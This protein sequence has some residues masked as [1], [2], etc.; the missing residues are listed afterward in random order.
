[1]KKVIGAVAVACLFLPV[2]CTRLDRV[3]SAAF[4]ISPDKLHVRV[5]ASDHRVPAE[6]MAV[7][8]HDEAQLEP[9]AAPERA[10][11]LGS[12]LI[13]EPRYEL[14]P[15]ALPTGETVSVMV[16][17]GTGGTVV[18]GE[19]SIEIPP[20]ALE[21]DTEISIT[22][23]FAA[24]E[25]GQL[26]N[27]TAGGGGYRF[28]PAGQ[29]FRTEAVIRLPYEASLEAKPAV[30]EALTTYYF[31]TE[32]ERWEALRRLGVDEEARVLIS[33][34]THFTD[35]I[36]G[37]LALP[38]G[39]EPLSFNIN[40]IKGLEAADPSAGVLQLEGLEANHMGSANFRFTLAV[41]AGRAGMT[42]AVA[43]GYSSDGGNGILG[44]GWS[45][46]AG[47]EITYDTRRGL[48]EYTAGEGNKGPFMLDGV[49][50]E[51]GGRENGGYRYRPLKESAFERILHY[52][53]P[54]DYWEVTDKRGTKR[55]YG[56]RGTDRDSDASW[57]GL[58]TGRK[59]RW[60]LESVEDSFGNRIRYEYAQDEGELYLTE[61]WYTEH[62]DS[63]DEGP[64]RVVFEYARSERQDI[65]VTGRGK[66]VAQT[67]WR[68]ERIEFLYGKTERI[69]SYRC[70]YTTQRYF[71]TT[72]LVKFGEERTSGGA[73]LWAYEFE[74]EEFEYDTRGRPVLFGDVERWDFGRHAIQE[75]HGESGGG[76]G[77]ISGGAGI[78]PS[79][80]T[81]IRVIR[82][83][84]FGGTSGYMQ[85][86]RTLVDINGD[87]K[88]DIVWM[89]GGELKAILNNGEG[90]DLGNNPETWGFEGG[91]GPG[92]IGLE[93]Q[94][95]NS[96]GHSTFVGAGLPIGGVGPNSGRTTQESWSTEEIGFADINGDGLADI[97]VRGEEFYWQNTGTS[98]IKTGYR[99]TG[100]G[101][102]IPGDMERVLDSQEKKAYDEVYY[103][104]VPF[105]AW[106][107][108]VSGTVELQQQARPARGA[109]NDSGVRL[110]TYW[111]P[112]TGKGT[113][114]ATELAVQYTLNKGDG[115]AGG[116]KTF[117]PVGR[118]NA[119]YFI[120]DAGNDI[121]NDDKGSSDIRWNIT[122][123]YT[124]MRYFEGLN[125]DPVFF[126]RKE[127]MPEKLGMLYN[128][129]SVQGNNTAIFFTEHDWKAR[130]W[131]DRD[132]YA[133]AARRGQMIPGVLSRAGFDLLQ[134]AAE[135]AT[136]YIPNEW[137]PEP[138]DYPF[139]T[140]EAYYHLSPLEALF[141]YYSY[142]DAGL[143]FCRVNRDYEAAL[144]MQDYLDNERLIALY[145]DNAFFFDAGTDFQGKAILVFNHER[146]DEFAAT[147]RKRQT[148]NYIEAQLLGL[149]GMLN[150]DQRE[151]L[152]TV[153]LPGRDEAVYP[154]Y[155]EATGRW[156][157]GDEAESPV[158]TA[159]EGSVGWYRN[160]ETVFL[161]DS[162]DGDDL[163]FDTETGAV[164]LAGTVVGTGAFIEANHGS[165]DRVCVVTDTE[166]KYRQVWHLSGYKE[167]LTR[168]S[169][170]KTAEL[171]ATIAGWDWLTEEP[172][173]HISKGWY[174]TLL[175]TIPTAREAFMLQTAYQVVGGQPNGLNT[176]ALTS[177]EQET[178]RRRIAGVVSSGFFSCYAAEEPDGGTE[179]APD[180]YR[181]VRTSGLSA[182]QEAML[183]LV[184]TALY[185]RG[186]TTVRRSIRYFED[187]VFPV[188]NNTVT[189]LTALHNGG[190]ERYTVTIAADY[191]WNSADDF[192][193][194][195][196]VA[197]APSYETNIPGY[198]AATDAEGKPKD[199]LVPTGEFETI[200]YRMETVELLPG[201][202]RQWYYGI[203]FK[204]QEASALHNA[205]PFSEAKL[206]REWIRARSIT[207]E[208]LRTESAQPPLYALIQ[209][210][211]QLEDG[212][213]SI[214]FDY[215]TGQALNGE[216]V[217]VGPVSLAKVG[218]IQTLW[219]FY[220]P[221]IAGDLIHTNR[222]GGNAYNEIRGMKQPAAAYGSLVMG[223]LN[224]S[225]SRGTDEV[226]TPSLGMLPIGISSGSNDS[227]AY[228][229]QSVQ[230]INGS[231]YAD[232]VQVAGKELLITPGVGSGTGTAFGKTYSMKNGG[233]VSRNYATVS[234][235]GLT[236]S[237]TGSYYAIRTARGLLQGNTQNGEGG[238]T[239]PSSDLGPSAG[240]G[241]NWS[242]GT[243]TQERG[244][245]DIN[246][247][248][249]PDFIDG[250]SVLLNIGSEFEGGYAWGQSYLGSGKTVSNG[251][252]ISLGA[253]RSAD[254]GSA[255]EAKAGGSVSMSGSLTVSDSHTAA[256]ETLLDINGNGLPDKVRKHANA[257][258]IEVAF[259]LGSTFADF[260]PF[261]LAS[262]QTGLL[263]LTE[264]MRTDANPPADGFSS[265]PYF[266]TVTVENKIQNLELGKFDLSEMDALDYSLSSSWGLSGG[267]DVSIQISIWIPIV[268][269]YINIPLSAGS[270]INWSSFTNQVTVRMIDINGN[271]LPDRV[272]RVA[273]STDI[274]VRLNKSGRVGLLRTISHP[275]GGR[276]AVDYAYMSGTPQMPQSKYVMSAVTREDG[277]G[278][279]DRLARG[280]APLGYHSE[281]SWTTEIVYGT[282]HY[283]RVAKEQYGFDT[284]T[285]RS[286]VDKTKRVQRFTWGVYHLKGLPVQ[287]V[288]SDETGHEW[289]R[290]TTYAYRDAP[291]ALQRQ[292][293]T[294]VW[295]N[296]QNTT[297]M[298]T[299]VDYE[300]DNSRSGPL[301]Y[302]NVTKIRDTV[303]TGTQKPP[304]LT[305][306]I[307][308]WEPG[309]AYFHAHPTGITVESGTTLIRRRTGAYDQR[310]GAL[311]LQTQKGQ[312]TT[313]QSDLTTKLTWD[314][315]GN[316]ERI[317]N[318]GS[319]WGAY[320]WDREHHQYPVTIT[321][322]GP[323]V[324]PYESHIAWDP[325][326]GVKTKETDENNQTITY[327][328]DEQG[329]LSAVYSPYDG[330]IPAVTYAYATP[331]GGRWY[332]VTRNKV[333]F[334]PGDTGGIR[335]VIAVDGLGRPLITAKDGA[336]WDGSTDLAGWNIAGPVA[337]DGKGRTVAQG[338]SVFL[339]ALSGSLEDV[340]TY[341]FPRKSGYDSVY[342]MRYPTLTEY[343]TQ[344]RPTTVTLP[345]GA[346]QRT[347]YAI[348][349]GH[350][351]VTVTDPL[352]N[353][354]VQTSDARGNITAVT[355]NSRTGNELTGA[356]YRY[357]AIG[358]MLAAV[359]YQGN[360]LSIEYD[361]M[362]RRTALTS[363]DIGRKEYV[364]DRSGNLIEESD[365]VLRGKGTAIYYEY[366]GMNRL[367]AITYPASENTVYEYGPPGSPYGSANRIV[368]VT[369][370]SGHIEYRYGALGETTAET[371]TILHMD[372]SRK[373]LYPAGV[374]Y[375]FTYRSNY[376]G[377]LEC[378]GFPDKETVRYGYNQGGQV[379][380]VTGERNG[381][382]FTYVKNIGYD[383]FSQR[384]FIEYGNGI[385]TT[386][387]YDPARRWLSGIT[388]TGPQGLAYQDIEYTLDAVGNVE[389]YTNNAYD[390]QT[391]QDYEYDDLYQLT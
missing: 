126:A 185:I 110:Y 62:K 257:D 29:Q 54:V 204:G 303:L 270:A 300:Y 384:V 343:D 144:G 198:G 58:D 40:S 201:G 26:A 63:R 4:R 331:E 148:W 376:L 334:D 280:E 254:P 175:R 339:E 73:Y 46:E 290:T 11:R 13:T 388:T 170:E 227:Y 229:W 131:L 225:Y 278:D 121:R 337:V 211:Y 219:V 326:W 321:R 381:T 107:A 379:N 374:A 329:R 108:P 85:T 199:E 180:A 287:E 378:I 271:G 10:E 220:A 20:G 189:F 18:L 206:Y 382:T 193:I 155:D 260:I 336:V 385:R 317:E 181:V 177:E 213:W 232:I 182:M 100:D 48:P 210:A 50:L 195:D 320:E 32:Q 214:E 322:G 82:T 360:V 200:E 268:C 168:L 363:P 305:A 21:A 361:L 187:G 203:W 230:D 255:R 345:D 106:R 242:N 2:Q 152:Y 179:P 65:G 31:D 94:N 7:P 113:D 136:L 69:R 272:L 377:Q 41:P 279:T 274:Y 47:G 323:G 83:Q 237:A 90:F 288:V 236:V 351:V 350:S 262:W 93:F 28:L 335:T 282:G 352:G 114:G 372:E 332:A 92:S 212:T 176:D 117:S 157:Y 8:L 349:D 23:L 247:D 98:F 154:Q 1:M 36:N 369:D 137:S 295:E 64:Y 38:E 76:S 192:S 57:A 291:Y 91:V 293:T 304:D 315:Y 74:Y 27:A 196:V 184:H 142:Y 19:A 53:E 165:T 133:W 390:Y 358:E 308:W 217:L 143:G 169:P 353:V 218:N 276:T 99:S 115:E 294:E 89:E 309:T 146:F 301:Q 105:R 25:T 209:P 316:L 43:V 359:D 253:W 61:I 383:E 243:T 30:L 150:E 250:G 42:P 347:A 111:G 367:T 24:G 208:E 3:S 248:G 340:V 51:Y 72:Q 370:E 14:P 318:V 327:T 52:T 375:E 194:E 266:G 205:E 246:G 296:G 87:G 88:P 128:E 81:D 9:G 233:D 311:I 306:E 166:N 275:Q 17:A 134:A 186:W 216:H 77:M 49:V 59:Y 66:Y 156:F 158:V 190:F 125:R 364:Y 252:S 207:Q 60:L 368:R 355:R 135:A 44:K 265:L 202:V 389:R 15:E 104:Q 160:S 234:T 159:E 324:G 112:G 244:L 269:Q 109:L 241:G 97:V 167:E 222:I 183:D 173:I 226:F 238:S 45:L 171:E 22:R 164:S 366:D 387:R 239:E 33:A 96:Y 163:L 258:Y 267:L 151:I 127:D 314:P 116:L 119:L 79:H 251:I 153:F 277:E 138:Y 365:T 71:G 67:R 6:A 221:W 346:P 139:L 39:P 197:H 371:R 132:T 328:Y 178:V 12:E 307:T 338:Q 231:G 386:Y 140:A 245:I 120:S 70:G 215:E 325:L 289:S 362:G 123:R 284:V 356:T 101:A 391:R 357:T 281:H 122:I 188:E 84:N 224:K 149:I 298:T 283:D 118:G 124:N 37:T 161:I 330:A 130:G 348:A 103:Q 75:R 240:G 319:S 373:L 344:D 302:G 259:N 102:G 68:L 145:S 256:T 174:D 162:Y 286:P 285:V 264:T 78:G 191:T 341:A 80:R 228:Q 342:A 147:I 235:S 333:S 354:S 95:S 55:V 223:S 310:T 86:E 292:V 299:A 313:T 261:P 34:T 312:E 172:W 297:A 263:G 141:A 35:M 380:E 5:P 249:L 16:S 56:S 273:G 129:A